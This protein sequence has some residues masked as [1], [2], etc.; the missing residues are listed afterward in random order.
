MAKKN[1]EDIK[2]EVKKLVAEIA[3]VP[4]KD[5][6]EDARFTEDLGVDS[7]KALEIVACIEKKLKLVISEADIP[8]IRS[9]GNVYDLI[10]KKV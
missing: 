7:M 2:K 9:L 8:K 1:L 3:E 5:L 6:T 4:E 10:A